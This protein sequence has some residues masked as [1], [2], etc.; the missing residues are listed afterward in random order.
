MSSA[1][2]RLLFILGILCLAF[3]GES[4]EQASG[5]LPP[6]PTAATPLVYYSPTPTAPRPSPTRSP[7]LPLSP[8]AT[9]LAPTRAPAPTVAPVRPL[10]P[11]PAP[12]LP[13]PIST[14]TPTATG[15]PTPR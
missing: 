2:A 7:L 4:C 15:S 12:A 9:A 8:A 14:R 6:T 1:P 11:T 5:L 10:L 3:L 13:T